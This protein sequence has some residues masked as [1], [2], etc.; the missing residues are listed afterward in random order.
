MTVFSKRNSKH[1]GFIETENEKIDKSDD[2]LGDQSRCRNTPD[3]GTSLPACTVQRHDSTLKLP[4]TPSLPGSIDRGPLPTPRVCLSV[5]AD[6]HPADTGNSLVFPRGVRPCEKPYEKCE[7]NKES[8]RESDHFCRAIFL[9][10]D[11][12]AIHV[13]WREKFTPLCKKRIIAPKILYFS[14]TIR[15]SRELIKVD[16]DTL[17]QREIYISPLLPCAKNDIELN[18]RDLAFEAYHGYRKRSAP[19]R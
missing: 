12:F 17:C 19:L 13:A 1:R 16:E 15:F 2:R 5:P 14:D 11:N 9:I 3:A 6:W 7:L 8:L 4:T 18:A 10:N